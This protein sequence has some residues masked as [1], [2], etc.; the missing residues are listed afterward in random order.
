MYRFEADNV[1]NSVL[2][3]M[4]SFQA[5]ILLLTA[6]LEIGAS[7]TSA[8]MAFPRIEAAPLTTFF[9]MLLSTAWINLLQRL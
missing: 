1:C 3:S 6:N 7:S 5:L 4:R 2:V 8:N 9:D